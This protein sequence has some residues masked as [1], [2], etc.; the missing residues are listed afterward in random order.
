M[1]RAGKL[2]MAF[3]TGGL[4]VLCM[5]TFASNAFSSGTPKFAYVANSGSNDISAY[6]IDSTTGALSLVI[7]SPFTAGYWPYLV[8]VD[9][10]GKFVY[11]PNNHSND[12]S[13][14]TIDS[15]TGALSP[16]SGSPFAAGNAPFGLAVDPSGKF[17][18]VTNLISDDIY[19]Y[20]IDSTTGALSPVSGS[21]F[22][23]RKR[24]C[25]AGGRSVGKVHLCGE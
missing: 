4:I 5:L 2:S 14:Y 20:T 9:P 24:S 11:A 25:R 16:V 23:G 12:I 19:G 10:S 3:L 21:P 1:K 8:A 7:G 18:Y 22:A 13:A 15:A 6:T 17:V